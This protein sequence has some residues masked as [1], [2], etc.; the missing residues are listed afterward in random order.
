M[1]IDVDALR[2]AET[3]TALPF[4]ISVPSLKLDDVPDLRQVEVSGTVTNLEGT[5]RVE[6]EMSVQAVLT[7]GRCLE[8]YDQSLSTALHEDYAR[9]PS[10]EQYPVEDDTVDL[11]P[12]LRN[13]VLL[14]LPLRPLHHPDC[15]GLC[16]LCGRN[17]NREPHRHPPEPRHSPFDVLKPKSSKRRSGKPGKSS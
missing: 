4:G 10:D 11:R 2:Q 8:S 15:R 9:H 12:M 16:S 7:C 3:G 13:L 6:G 1:K 14:E 17:L 5:L